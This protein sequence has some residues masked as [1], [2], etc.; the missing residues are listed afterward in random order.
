MEGGGREGQRQ[1]EEAVYLLRI[2]ASG[3]QKLG[4]NGETLKTP[5]KLKNISLY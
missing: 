1:E 3:W 4:L 5:G 2:E